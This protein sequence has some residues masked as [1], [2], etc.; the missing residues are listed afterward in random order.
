[1][2]NNK[3]KHSGGVSCSACNAFINKIE[4][5]IYWIKAQWFVVAGY[6]V[7]YYRKIPKYADTQKICCNHP[8]I[9]TRWLYQRVMHPKDAA[10]IANSVDPDQTAPSLI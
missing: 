9:W 3:N 8:K 5:L 2:H 6:N 10:G 1:M 7:K 4:C